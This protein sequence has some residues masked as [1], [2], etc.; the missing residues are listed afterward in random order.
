[1][2]IYPELRILENRVDRSLRE[3]GIANIDD[4]TDNPNAVH[5]IAPGTRVTVTDSGTSQ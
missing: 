1:M 5:A 3:N 2:I 4:R